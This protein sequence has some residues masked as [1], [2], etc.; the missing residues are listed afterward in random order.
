MVLAPR[1]AAL[2]P[3]LTEPLLREA[4]E[5][6]RAFGGEWSQAWPRWPPA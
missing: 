5:A 3:H 1:L 6:A 2:A 4:L